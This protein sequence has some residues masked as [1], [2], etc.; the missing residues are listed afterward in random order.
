MKTVEMLHQAGHDFELPNTKGATALGIAAQYGH[1]PVVQYLL[2]HRALPDLVDSYKR[3]PLMR[4]LEGVSTPSRVELL[5][6]LLLPPHHVDVD[7]LDSNS[8]SALSYAAEH[9]NVEAVELLLRAG[10][11]PNQQNQQQ[12]TP[13][14]YAFHPNDIHD[15]TEFTGDKILEIAHLFINYGARVDLL[16]SKGRGAIWRGTSLE[17]VMLLV[18]HG[19]DIDRPD[20][21]GRAPISLAVQAGLYELVR[22]FAENGAEF[23]RPD[24]IGRSPLSWAIGNRKLDIAKYLLDK[25]A[26]PNQADQTGRTPL[27]WAAAYNSLETVKVLHDGKAYIDAPDHKG[28]SPLM[29]AIRGG[30]LETAKYLV[31]HGALVDHQDKKGRTALSRVIEYISLTYDARKRII[32]F[33]LNHGADAHR[34]DLTNHTPISRARAGS[35]FESAAIMEQTLARPS[36]GQPKQVL[37]ITLTVNAQD[38][39]TGLPNRGRALKFIDSGT[40]LF[41]DG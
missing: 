32:R 25:G 31:K 39:L 40:F 26:K 15:Q 18:E 23:D 20:K 41:S 17:A 9:H 12:I 29:W 24:N 6:L 7:R 19:A 16:D 3:S 1:L 2:D 22:Y 8:R 37:K 35:Y 30:Y 38:K 33:L 4:A 10:A 27:S 34:K 21:K 5:S 28:Q 13:L 36:Y 14:I 11:N